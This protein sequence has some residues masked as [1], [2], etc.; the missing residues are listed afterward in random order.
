MFV[1][2][3]LDEWKFLL[4]MRFNL[5]FSVYLLISVS[6]LKIQCLL[7]DYKCILFPPPDSLNS[8]SFYVYIYD[9]NWI[10]F[11]CKTCG[12]SQSYFF[13]CISSCYS[14]NWWTEFLYRIV[15]TPLWSIKWI[16]TCRS[17]FIILFVYT[18]ARITLFRLLQAYK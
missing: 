14:T 6:C 1:F 2:V 7:Q 10:N 9:S 16:C 12:R 3:H 15:L 11:L 18:Y 17:V 13:M 8:S 4:F 5:S